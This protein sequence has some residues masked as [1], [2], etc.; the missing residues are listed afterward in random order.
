MIG[1]AAGAAELRAEAA[2]VG[3]A[4]P[5]PGLVWPLRAWDTGF[6]LL[7]GR[8]ADAERL[9]AEALPIGVRIG[10]PFARPV[11]RGHCGLL[12]FERRNFDEV[13]VSFD[14]A[15]RFHRG[16]VQWAHAFVGRALFAAGRTEE[17]AARLARLGR[18]A[19]RGVPRN[20]RWTGTA[21]EAA[22]LCADLADA[23]RAAELAPLLEPVASQHAVLA[24]PVC[25][26]GP[27]T[28]AL[29]RLYTVLGRH[30]EAREALDEARASAAALGARPA[31]R[32][33]ELDLAAHHERHGSR[34]AARE[35][36]AAAAAL[37][38]ELGL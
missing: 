30:D 20:I 10:H 37:T 38:T 5:H 17:A 1:D 3:G 32:R 15:R 28:H 19:F 25:Y 14:P 18:D 36:H 8:F 21:I 12:A 24:L 9:A 34:S 33:I 22:N 16:A 4:S 13:F 35:H 2:G 11:H 26:G 23:E 27:A 6:A 31:V 7:Q 29:G